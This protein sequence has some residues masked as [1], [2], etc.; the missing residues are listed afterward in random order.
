MTSQK[1][2]NKQT[3]P[4]TNGSISLPVLRFSQDEAAVTSGRSSGF[5][6]LTF[7]VIL[8]TGLPISNRVHKI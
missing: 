8:L 3:K 1:K 7:S 2:T 6:R 5:L 4:Q